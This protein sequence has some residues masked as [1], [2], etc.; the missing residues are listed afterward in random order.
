M[1]IIAIS[2]SLRAT[3]LN[4]A[5]LNAASRLAPAGVTIEMFEGIGNLPFFN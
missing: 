3:S 2:G 4:T 1:N 5:V